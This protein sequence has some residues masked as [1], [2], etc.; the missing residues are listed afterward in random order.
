MFEALPGGFPGL[1]SLVSEFKARGVRVLWPW[2]GWDQFTR[3]D[4]RGRGDAA[5]F[6]ALLDVTGADG[7]NADSAKSGDTQ[8]DGTVHLT[9][10][11]R[12]VAPIRRAVGRGR[13][14]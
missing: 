10:G 6:A 3:P 9:Q 8:A 5:R 11:A 14:D 1:R 13:F 2:N 7:A 4:P 12:A